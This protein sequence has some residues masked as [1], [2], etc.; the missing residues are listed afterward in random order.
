MILPHLNVHKLY[1]SKR[2]F[3]VLL[4]FTVLTLF[5][6]LVI[7]FFVLIF[8]EHCFRGRPFDPLVYTETRWSQGKPFTLYKFNIFLYDIILAMRERGEFVQTKELERSN[9]LLW[10]GWILKQIYLDELPQLFNVLMGDMSIVGPRP[11]NTQV[12]EKL[13]EHGITDKE[14][15]KA[16]LT[17]LYQATHKINR[18]GKSQEELDREYVNFY[19]KHPWYRVLLFD[20]GIILKTVVVLIYARGI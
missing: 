4:S 16:G 5:S 6:P 3:D 8:I 10:I 14:T 17:G 12:R 11:I 13:L 7:F 2:L 20:L 19:V 1:K 9:Q 15:V 18:A